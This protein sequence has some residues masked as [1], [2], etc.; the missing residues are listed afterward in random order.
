[1]EGVLVTDCK[2]AGLCSKSPKE[3]AKIVSVVDKSNY[4]AHS[5]RE[6]ELAILRARSKHYHIITYVA[7]QSKVAKTTFH[8]I[9]CM[10]RLPAASEG[11]KDERIRLIL[12][13]EL[14][15]VVYN[16]ENLANPEIFG[17]RE[18]LAEEELFAWEFAY[19][20]VLY[21]GDAYR[22]DIRLQRFIFSGGDLRDMIKSLVTADNP[23]I[24][25]DLMQS[26]KSGADDVRVLKGDG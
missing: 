6:I 12:A 7:S 13:H 24:C 5:I 18:P 11:M 3:A 23:D 1:L 22:S 14:G 2:Y 15:H 9:C 16:I 17:S 10:I 25:A 20:L 19:N 8:D 26:L 21:K 4:L